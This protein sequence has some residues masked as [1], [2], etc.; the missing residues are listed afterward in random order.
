M[1]STRNGKFANLHSRSWVSVG[2]S[3]MFSCWY[4]EPGYH[5]A[6]LA[7]VAPPAADQA[8][9]LVSVPL[10]RKLTERVGS[11]TGRI[12][13]LALGNG[14]ARSVSRVRGRD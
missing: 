1:I 11:N 8:P 7:V 6:R 12:I 4:R 2:S 3:P 5:R 9:S 13:T 10:P 14:G